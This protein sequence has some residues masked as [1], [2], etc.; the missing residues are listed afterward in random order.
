M[1]LVQKRLEE[2]LDAGGHE[3][4]GCPERDVCG[5]DVGECNVRQASG[6]RRAF[7]GVRWRRG[8]SRLER[9]VIVFGQPCQASHGSK[10]NGS[11][12][13]NVGRGRG[14]GCPHV[15]ERA[16]QGLLVEPSEGGLN[17]HGGG[18]KNRENRG[19]RISILGPRRGPRGSTTMTGRHSAM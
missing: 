19:R 8:G 7:G 2:T 12:G 10:K 15:R 5:L 18:Q 1:V 11:G 17:L 4:G 13:L 16:E 6:G 3:R 14:A 9:V